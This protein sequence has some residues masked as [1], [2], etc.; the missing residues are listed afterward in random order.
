MNTAGKI[1]RRSFMGVMLTLSGS[2]AAAG[3][4]S[5][6][7][8]APAAGAS[9]VGFYETVHRPSLKARLGGTETQTYRVSDFGA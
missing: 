4:P 9:H 5:T 8:P 1:D 3:L 7:T 2:A 6:A